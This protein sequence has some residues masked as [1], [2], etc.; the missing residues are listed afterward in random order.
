MDDFETF[1][2]STYNILGIAFC[3]VGRYGGHCWKQLGL[4]DYGC[5]SSLL[6]L[7]VRLAK[8]G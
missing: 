4:R 8:G 6:V 5:T 2:D 7:F 1:K 3:Y